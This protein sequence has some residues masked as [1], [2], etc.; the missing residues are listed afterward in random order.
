MWPKRRPAA[1]PAAGAS[2][3]A[4]SSTRGVG[5]EGSPEAHT[6]SQIYSRTHALLASVSLLACCTLSPVAQPAVQ[7]RMI[8]P[9]SMGGNGTEHLSTSLIA[10]PQRA[11]QITPADTGETTMILDVHT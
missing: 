2:A 1:R 11:L 10:L 7:R 3:P 9:I 8:R 5:P 6:R 4:G